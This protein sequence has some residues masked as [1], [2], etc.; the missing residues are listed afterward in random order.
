MTMNKNRE[1]LNDFINFCDSHPQL[2]FWQ[3][4]TIWSD[5]GRILLID[6]R[7][8]GKASENDPGEMTHDPFYYIGKNK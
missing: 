3:A 6:Y 2:R 8:S 4:L 1:V 7:W 5:Y